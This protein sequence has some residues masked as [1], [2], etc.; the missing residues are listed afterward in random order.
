MQDI[1][2]TVKLH[3]VCLYRVYDFSFSVGNAIRI[4]VLLLIFMCG[5]L[6]GSDSS[7]GQDAR[8]HDNL[9]VSMLLDP[10]PYYYTTALRVS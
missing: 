5:T 1:F 10:P 8:N 6:N 4:I 9:A 7:L 2:S 3:L